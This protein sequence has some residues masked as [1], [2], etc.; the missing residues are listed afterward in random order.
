MPE[1]RVPDQAD[2]VG[3]RDGCQQLHL[4]AY[5]GI[6]D[7]HAPGVHRVTFRRPVGLEDRR[8]DGV[9]RH[10]LL[11]LGG[12][13]LRLVRELGRLGL[14]QQAADPAQHAVVTASRARRRAGAARAPTA[15]AAAAGSRAGRRCAAHPRAA[16]RSATPLPAPAAR[17]GARRYRPRTDRPVRERPAPT[18]APP[19]R[20]ARGSRRRCAARARRSGATTRGTEPVVAS[21]RATC[22]TSVGCQPRSHVSSRAVRSVRVTIPSSSIEGARVASTWPRAPGPRRRRSAGGRRA[23][24][25]GR[26]MRRSNMRRHACPAVPTRDRA[27]CG[28]RRAVHRARV[29]ARPSRVGPWPPPT[30]SPRPRTLLGVSD[31]TVRRWIDSGRLP[32][33]REGGGPAVVDGAELARV[34]AQLHSHRHPAPPARRRPATG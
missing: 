11:R 27:G 6:P 19:R 18:A 8:V 26:A 20:P 2:V 13:R 29:V 28:Q 9:P 30:G 12:Q 22:T 10:Q 25:V 32:A 7:V 31:D 5:V 21:R 24:G 14:G 23:A 33:R 16:A 15:T 34:A 17:P 3:L 1:T 4:G